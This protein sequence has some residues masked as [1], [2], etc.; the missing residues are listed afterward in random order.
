MHIPL[1]SGT[2]INRKGGASMA[3]RKQTATVDLKVRMKEP[4]RAALE[5]EA[6]KKG[7]S[8]NAEAV[9][10]LEKSFHSEN[11]GLISA[12]LRAMADTPKWID[13][14]RGLWFSPSFKNNMKEA[15]IA[16]IDTLP[17]A[18][19]DRGLSDEEFEHCR[20]MVAEAEQEG[21]AGELRPRHGR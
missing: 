16:F 12:L 18:Q 4:L 3:R 6:R 13:D 1:P 14:G 17:E 5:T 9:R 7:H 21:A 2:A 20:R 11:Q 10:R 15:V 19:P 8:L